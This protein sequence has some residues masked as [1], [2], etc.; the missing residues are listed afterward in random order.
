MDIKEKVKNII[1][2]VEG[3]ARSKILNVERR[4][5]L[6]LPLGEYDRYK[7]EST[8]LSP[9]SVFKL[10]MLMIPEIQEKF[11]EILSLMPLANNQ[12]HLMPDNSFR[13][14]EKI[15]DDCIKKLGKYRFEDFI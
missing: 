9:N 1:L 2:S 4:H 14:A 13:D 10:E 8:H 6:K 5:G 12:S 3:K 7:R 11:I 15:R